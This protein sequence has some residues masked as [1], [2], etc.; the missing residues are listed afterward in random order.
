MVPKIVE[1]IVANNPILMEL[2]SAVHTSG[3]PHG[4]FQLSKVKPFQTKL[5]LPESLNEKTKVYRT[6]MKR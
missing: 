5:D 6:G 2:P 1:K 4:F 3:A